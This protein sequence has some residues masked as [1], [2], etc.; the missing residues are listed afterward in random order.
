MK[1]VI[2]IPTY[3]EKENTQRMIKALSK[4]V[5]IVKDHTL[6]VLYVDDSSPDGTA[7]VVE[8]EMKKYPW[9]HLLSGSPKK[10][11]GVAYA[12]GMAYAMK[13]LSADYL[14]EFDSDFQHPPRD[15]PRMVNEIDHGYDYI[16]ASRYVP[17]GSVPANWT[18]DRKA[19]SLVGNLIARIGLLIPQVHDCTGGFKLSRVKGFMDEFDFDTLLSK[20]FAYKIHLLAYMVVTKKAKIKEVPFSFE[21]RIVGNSK[22]STNEMKE[23]LKVIL[24]FQ[25][26]NPSITKFF[27]FGVVGGVGFLVNLFGLRFFN[28]VY[29][30]FSWPIGLVNFVANATA[31][32]I[33]IIS[34]FIFNNLWTF[35]KEKITN[36]VQYISKF[37]AFNFSSIIGGIL[38]PSFI[39]GVGTQIFG[40]Q[41]REVFLILA[42]FGFTVPFNWFVYNKFIWGKKNLK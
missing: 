16:I 15:I 17:G 20:K 37:F 38:V 3:N 4:I 10:G 13:Q 14:M 7:G 33:S 35:S 31:A 19:V 39:I 21:N 22:Y 42:L 24:L 23:S 2:I 18:I 26:K 41:Y 34:N 12:R 28:G 11:L 29:Q 32:E 27:K 40:D 1:V 8:S 5:P 9:L 25:L 30:Q 36:P 6:E